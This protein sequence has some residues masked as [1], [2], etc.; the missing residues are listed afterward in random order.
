MCFCENLGAVPTEALHNRHNRLPGTLYSPDLVT[1]R[2]C[3]VEQE[4]LVKGDQNLA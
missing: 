1:K 3:A 2:N 4:V